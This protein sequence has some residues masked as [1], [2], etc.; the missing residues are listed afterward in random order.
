ME[1]KRVLSQESCQGICMDGSWLFQYHLE[2]TQGYSTF[3]RFDASAFGFVIWGFESIFYGPF[4]WHTVEFF[5]FK[6]SH[7][8]G[9]LINKEVIDK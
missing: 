3:G 9:A 2:L 5:L 4:C 6:G 1:D 7:I 8:F